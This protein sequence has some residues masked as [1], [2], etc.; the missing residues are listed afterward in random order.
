VASQNEIFA[1]NPSITI[2]SN[3]CTNSPSAYLSPILAN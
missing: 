1:P 2:T 3:S